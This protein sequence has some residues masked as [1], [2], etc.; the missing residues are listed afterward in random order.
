MTE[1]DPEP[2]HRRRR[3]NHWDRPPPPRDLRWFMSLIGTGLM[4]LGMLTLGFVAYQLWGTGIETSRAQSSLEDEFERVLASSPS[5]ARATSPA[6]EE[7]ASAATAPDASAPAAAPPPPV[8]QRLPAFAEG[9]AVARLQIPR[10]GLDV[11]VVAGVDRDDLKRGPGHYPQTP[12]PGQLGNAAIAGH[13][14]TYGEPF[15]DID[16]LLAGDEVTVTTPA[17]TFTYLVD[18]SRIVAPSDGYVLDTVDEDV[19]RLTLTSCHP[20]YSA[21]Q[22]IVVSAE[23]AVRRSSPVGE[24]VIN[25]GRPAGDEAQPRPVETIPGARAD[26]TRAPPDT[27]PNTSQPDGRGSG[28][29]GVSTRTAPPAPAPASDRALDPEVD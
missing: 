15:A 18:G 24:P 3:I 8:A 20:R 25:Y 17:G 29:G 2:A 7:T 26:E 6:P 11:I 1:A 13:R 10:I 19:A 4:V 28:T 14:T 21:S 16:Q 12:L 9:D 5:T 27:S 22:R 23:L